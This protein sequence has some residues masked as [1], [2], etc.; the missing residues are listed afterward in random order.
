MERQAGCAGK[1][2]GEH[3]RQPVDGHTE[4]FLKDALTPMWYPP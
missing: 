3:K 4:A 2:C 1:Q